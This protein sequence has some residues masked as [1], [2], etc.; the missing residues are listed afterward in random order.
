MDNLAAK[1]ASVNDAVNGVVWGVP[2]LVLL[3]GTGVLMTVLTRFF[4]FRR[5]GHMWKNTIGGL[6]SKKEIRKSHDR[7]SISQFQALCTALSATIDIDMMSMMGQVISVE[8]FG[9]APATAGL[10]GDVNH[11]SEVNLADV[12]AV[13]GIILDK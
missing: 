12:N 1:I 4:Q 6:F 8:L 13:I 2:A 5:F 3:I 9:V 11:D 10:E 7:H